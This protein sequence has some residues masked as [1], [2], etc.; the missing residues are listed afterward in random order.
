MN[1]EVILAIVIAG[2]LGIFRGVEWLLRRGKV[3]PDCE[4]CLLQLGEIREIVR[5]MG[6]DSKVRNHTGRPLYMRNPEHDARVIE[7]LN[8]IRH[9]IQGRGEP[10]VR[11]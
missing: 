9:L 7:I 1:N 11:D 10:H 3:S 4:K 2:V 8:D 5:T 6:A